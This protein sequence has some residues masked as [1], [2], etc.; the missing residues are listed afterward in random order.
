M[1][2]SRRLELAN[3][4]IIGVQSFAEG[5]ARALEF[6]R[7]VDAGERLPE[8]D[9][10]LTFA[11]VEQLLSELTPA[12]LALLYTLKQAGA[13]SIYALAKRVGRH[14]SNVHRDVQKLIEHELIAK[15]NEDR[16]YVPWAEVR[17]GL[18]IGEAAA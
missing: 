4:A 7:R 12:R 2:P 6:A 13:Q 15:D 3:K 17:I 10:H 16:I 14:Y 5:A 9:Y 11:T 1:R 8:A 18:T